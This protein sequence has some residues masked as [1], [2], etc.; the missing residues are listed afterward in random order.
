MNEQK[1]L[2]ERYT[3]DQIAE[4]EQGGHYLAVGVRSIDDSVIF[5][6]ASSE[7]DLSTMLNER[8]LTLSGVEIT[9][10]YECVNRRITANLTKVSGVYPRKSFD[11]SGLNRILLKP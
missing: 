6:P 10:I 1:K 11:Y 4:S 2:P 3:R 9:A 7:E 5:I 8:L